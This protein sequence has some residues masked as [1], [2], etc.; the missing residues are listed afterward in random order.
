MGINGLPTRV[1]TIHS[2]VGAIHIR[3]RWAEE[4]D[5]GTPE[6]FGF[7]EFSEHVLGRPINPPFGI[8]FE[9]LFYHGGD[10]VAW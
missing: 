3:A 8:E 7:A 6:V 10:N 5:G 4:E 9:E 2:Q 1:S